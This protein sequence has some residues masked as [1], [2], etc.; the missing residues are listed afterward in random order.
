MVAKAPKVLIVD[1]NPANLVALSAILKPL[2]VALV[3]ARSGEDALAKV[4]GETFAVA[5]L[6]VQ[7]PGMDGFETAS[8]MRVTPGGRG[9]PIIFLTAIYQDEICTRKGYDSGAADYLTKPFDAGV[10]RA[11]VKAFADLLRAARGRA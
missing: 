5:L 3:E 7:M 4:A 10:L 2:R 6:D 11:R 8:R 1:D 9:L